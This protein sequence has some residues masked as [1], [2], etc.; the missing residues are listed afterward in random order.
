MFRMTIQKKIIL[1]CVPLAAFSIIVCSFLM[2]NEAIKVANNAIEK[3]ANEQLIS[4]RDFKKAEIE[5]LFATI[6]NQVITMASSPQTFD[7]SSYLK[8]AFFRY[9]DE[10]MIKLD[11]RALSEYYKQYYV[12]E[13][14]RVNHDM[15]PDYG[16]FITQMSELAKHMQLLLMATQSENLDAKGQPQKYHFKGSSEYALYH[17]QLDPWFKQYANAFLYE[18]IYIIEEDKGH[19]L[20]SVRKNIDTGTSLETGPFKNSPLAK[21][22]RQAKKLAPGETTVVDYTTYEPTYHIPAAFIASPINMQGQTAGIL[23]FQLPVQRI[24]NIMSLN[25][26][27]K[28]SGL[29]DTGELYLVGPDGTMRSEAR[30]LLEDQDGFYDALKK[31]G[32]SDDL[33]HD[34]KSRHSSVGIQPIRAQSVNKALN[35]ESGI[36]TE[37]DY[38]QVDVLSAYAPLNINGLNWI[39]LSQF[40]KEEALK[41]E[42]VLFDSL[43]SQ[44]MITTLILLSVACIVGWLMGRYLAKPIELFNDYLHRITKSRDLTENYKPTTNDEL[45]TL[46][47]NLNTFTNEIKTFLAE[48][49]D[50]T[51]TLSKTSYAMHV[52]A[53]E[54]K[55]FAKIQNKDNDGI[56]VATNQLQA[57]IINI[58]ELTENAATQAQTTQKTCEKNTKTTLSAKKEMELLAAQMD[59]TTKTIA[60]L[61]SESKE[62]SNILDVIQ[63][64]AEQTNLLALNAAIE[65]ARAGEQGRGF[66]VVADEVRT[67]AA[68]TSASTEEIRQRIEALQKGTSCAVS[69][70]QKSKEHTDTSI[71][72]VADAMDG[73]T[74]VSGHIVVLNDMAVQIASATEEQTAV[75]TEISNNM[76]HIKNMSSEIL[77]KT[78]NVSG[79]SDELSA[80]ANMIKNDLQKFKIR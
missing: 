62:I 58:A 70:V 68:R 14:K 64:I 55:E 23:V 76:N 41:D 40:D 33:I 45:A 29:G 57:S 56:A 66:A 13:Y 42:E 74:D 49:S 50:T 72:K 39:L 15:E 26:K 9:P 73:I 69:S 47:G 34:I 59:E 80:S 44:S 6:K 22:F 28:E 67:L 11:D 5:Q 19:I 48:V 37:S 17:D 52:D 46:G 16:S 24:N 53:T 61:E 8:D 3:R 10:S 75:T 21:V 27:W 32:L 36:L 18:N 60:Q 25:G 71:N 2:G 31:D 78:S 4:V 20:Y 1:A 51:D 79:S 30:F 12:P 35:G 43:V 77:T 38:R 65:A 7:A 63:S 54:T